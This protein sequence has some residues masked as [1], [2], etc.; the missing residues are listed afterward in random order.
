MMAHGFSSSGLFVLANINFLNAGRRNL[1]LYK[2]ISSIYTGAA[3]LWFVLLIANMAAPP[4]LNLVAELLIFR[5]VLKV[6]LYLGV[7]LGVCT[8]IAACYNLYLYRS[9]QGVLRILCNPSQI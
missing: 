9:Q 1:L 7:L 5:S 6:S 8:F 3:L 2:G 4:A